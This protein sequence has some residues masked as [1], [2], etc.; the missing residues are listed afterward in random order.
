LL[1][2]LTLAGIVLAAAITTSWH[3]ARYGI[4]SLPFC[5]SRRFGEVTTKSDQAAVQQ[6]TKL[7]L[8]STSRPPSI[9]PC[10]R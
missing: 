9:V 7:E 4:P 8:S 3:D 5:G 10:L 1:G 6:I 2:L